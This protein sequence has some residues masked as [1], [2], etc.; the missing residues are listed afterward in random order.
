MPECNWMT[1]TEHC[2]VKIARPLD[3]HVWLM[4]SAAQI[5]TC[6]FPYGSHGCFGS[7]DGWSFKAR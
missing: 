2:G 1:A 7:D 6:V 4:L 3:G 5:T